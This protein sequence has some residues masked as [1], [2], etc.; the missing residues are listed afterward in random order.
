MKLNLFCRITGLTFFVLNC[1]AVENSRAQLWTMYNDTTGL[2]KKNKVKELRVYGY[3]DQWS[4]SLL[5]NIL[6]YDSSGKI[7]SQTGFG[8]DKKQHDFDSFVYNHDGRLINSMRIAA[9][10]QY[11]IDTLIYNNEGLLIA[12]KHLVNGTGNQNTTYKYDHKGRLFKIETYSNSLLWFSSEISYD[13]NSRRKGEILISLLGNSYDTLFWKTG[14]NALGFVSLKEVFSSKNGYS[15]SRFEYDKNNRM[16]RE[17]TKGAHYGRSFTSKYNKEGN[18]KEDRLVID[19]K[20][21]GRSV[22]NTFYKYY[23][24]NLKFE[25]AHSTNGK[26]YYREKLVYCFYQ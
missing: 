12:K 2:Y 1:C 10:A 9:T 21:N 3:S 5:T 14:Y 23:S 6:R 19:D 17:S 16:V 7:I 4:D 18:K 20:V 8:I 15:Y 24:N 11:E 22:S 26:I 13:E 25:I